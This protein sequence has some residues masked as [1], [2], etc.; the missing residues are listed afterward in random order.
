[1]RMGL[2]TGLILAGAFGLFVWE[3]QRGASLAEARTTAMNVIVMVE[4]FYLFNCRSL[5]RSM[6]SVGVLSN[7]WVVAGAAGMLGLQLAVTYVPLLNRLLHT[8]PLPA[9]SWLWITA[10][11]F[12]A[13]VVVGVEK[14]L[15]QR[16][17]TA[18]QRLATASTLQSE[19]CSEEGEA[20]N[21]P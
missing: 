8:A 3:Q 10:V 21:R 4:W 11:G 19:P 2:V 7:W 5:T 14:W 15:R 6:F 13:Y 18:G 1:M 12:V 17:G 9:D 16:L 20:G